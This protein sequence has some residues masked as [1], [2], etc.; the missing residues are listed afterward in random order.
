[1]RQL[2]HLHQL[3]VAVYDTDH[4][5]MGSEDPVVSSGELIHSSHFRNWGHC[6]VQ[7]RCHYCRG[8]ESGSQ[9]P[10]LGASQQPVIPAPGDGLVLFYSHQGHLYS[11]YTHLHRIKVNLKKVI[12]CQAWWHIPV[13]SALGRQRQT[14]CSRLV[15]S[16]Q[17]VI[18]T[19]RSRL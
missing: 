4:G 9:H 3:S 8:S 10:L 15:W 17:Q 14:E 2:G 11:V 19:L 1:M 6:S 13:I 5:N 12:S 18:Y 7:S 16:T